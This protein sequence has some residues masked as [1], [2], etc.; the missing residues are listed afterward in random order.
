MLGRCF[1]RFFLET[2][3][4]STKN[5]I[6]ERFDDRIGS[7]FLFVHSDIRIGND[8][9]ALRDMLQDKALEFVRV[10][11]APNK[12]LGFIET[13]KLRPE[14]Q[15]FGVLRVALL[16]RGFDRFQIRGFGFGLCRCAHNFDGGGFFGARIVNGRRR[17]GRFGLNEVSG[18]FSDPLGA[19]AN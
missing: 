8:R 15:N 4:L 12:F 9:S 1:A 7:H 14:R 2:F 11:F 5:K 17:R 18:A 3:E 13:F 16:D 10:L 19:A 6:A